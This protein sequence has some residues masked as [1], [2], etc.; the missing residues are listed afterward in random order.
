MGGLGAML[1]LF[2]AIFR[3]FSGF[4]GCLHSCWFLIDFFGFLLDFGGFGEG[5]GK[6]LGRFFDDFLNYLGK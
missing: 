3:I 2:F 6:I 5:L 1:G 4:L